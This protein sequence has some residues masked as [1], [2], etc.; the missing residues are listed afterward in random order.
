M[1]QVIV[2]PKR[3]FE[4]IATGGRYDS[5]IASFRTPVASPQPIHA[6]GVNIAI[7]KLIAAVLTSPDVRLK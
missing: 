6:V 2:D 4:V 1:V 5:L 3:K 7:E